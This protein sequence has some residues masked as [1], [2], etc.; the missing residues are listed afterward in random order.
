MYINVED[1]SGNV[2][3]KRIKDI[4]TDMKQNGNATMYHYLVTRPVHLREAFSQGKYLSVNLFTEREK[5]VNVNGDMKRKWPRDFISAE[6]VLTTYQDS[7]PLTV[8]HEGL[9]F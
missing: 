1:S 6:E 5:H 4:L 2:N 8:L 3:S 9:E 7:K